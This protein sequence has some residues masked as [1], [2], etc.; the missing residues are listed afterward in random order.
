MPSS[1][2]FFLNLTV[3]SHNSV[4]TRQQAFFWDSLLTP[5]RCGP[6]NQQC[7]LI[8]CQKARYHILQCTCSH[9]TQNPLLCPL[10]VLWTRDKIGGRKNSHNPLV[11][12]NVGMWTLQTARALKTIKYAFESCSTLYDQVT[13]R[14]FLNLTEPHFS[15]ENWMLLPPSHDMRLLGGIRHKIV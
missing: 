5:Q 15:S 14:E 9:C 12:Q 8:S 4:H 7:W 3:Q 13:L 1:L 11:T 6:Q 10:S 2:C